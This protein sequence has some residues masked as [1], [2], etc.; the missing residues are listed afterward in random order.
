M[1]KNSPNSTVFITADEKLAER[2]AWAELT[3]VSTRADIAVFLAVVNFYQRQTEGN[4]PGDGVWQIT[5]VW[6]YTIP[7]GNSNVLIDGFCSGSWA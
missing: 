6:S 1:C 3:V 7:V 5:P 2:Q 4:R